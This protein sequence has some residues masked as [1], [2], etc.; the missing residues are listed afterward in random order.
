MLKTIA[1]LVSQDGGTVLIGVRDDLQIVGLPEGANTASAQDVR[2]RQGA[3]KAA[4]RVT[5]AFSSVYAFSWPQEK[6]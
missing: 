6:S 2:G 1:A 5:A 3:E 4:T